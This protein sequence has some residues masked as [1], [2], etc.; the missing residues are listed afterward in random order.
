MENL[1]SVH[2]CWTGQAS[3]LA[4]ACLIA[5]RFVLLPDSSH[6]FMSLSWTPCVIFLSVYKFRPLRVHGLLN[7]CMPGVY[8]PHIRLTAVKEAQYG[9]FWAKVWEQPG[10][11]HVKKTMAALNTHAALQ[12]GL[13]YNRLLQINRSVKPAIIRMYTI[14][15]CNCTRWKT[16]P[17]I[18]NDW[19]FVSTVENWRLL[20]PQARISAE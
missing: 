14:S 4:A 5:Q 17:S 7:Y 13:N 16:I 11:V 8:C 12:K 2:C 10:G 9:V 18:V 20:F 3:D 6:L 1:L 19:Q 15:M